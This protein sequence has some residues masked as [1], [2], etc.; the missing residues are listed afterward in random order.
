METAGRRAQKDARGGSLPDD[1]SVQYIEGGKV[2]WERGRESGIP[3]GQTNTRFAHDGTLVKIKAALQE[4][5][6]QVD[7]QIALHPGHLD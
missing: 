4:A 3:T 2:I 6:E 1:Y 5:M 7:G